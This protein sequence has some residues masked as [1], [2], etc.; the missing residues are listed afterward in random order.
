MLFGRFVS[1]KIVLELFR[2]HCQRQELLSGCYG[3][4]FEL[5]KDSFPSHSKPEQCVRILCINL[6]DLNFDFQRDIK[7]PV[8]FGQLLLRVYAIAAK[9]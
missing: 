8:A 5:D 1:N 6:I 2:K 9:F 3:S 7:Q 4:I